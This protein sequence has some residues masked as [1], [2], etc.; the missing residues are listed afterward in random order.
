MTGGKPAP[1]G[2]RS[3][4]FFCPKLRWSVATDLLYLVLSIQTYQG[5]LVVP[6]NTVAPVVNEQ[7][8][9]SIN[10]GDYTGLQKQTLTA[11]NTGTSL[12]L[13][14]PPYNAAFFLTTTTPIEINVNSQGWQVVTTAFLTMAPVTSVQLRNLLITPPAT[15]TIDATTYWGA[16]KTAP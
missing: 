16:F 4:L 3:G 9:A 8:A 12:S 7:V 14:S 11:G 2:N 6:D 15:G 5:A 1:P 10:V 13:T